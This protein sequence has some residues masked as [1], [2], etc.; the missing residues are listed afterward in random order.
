[1]AEVTPNYQFSSVQ[2]VIEQRQ[3]SYDT[4]ARTAEQRYLA[5][6]RELR[7]TLETRHGA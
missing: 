3:L 7:R 1:M 5:L 2:D 4:S 6:S